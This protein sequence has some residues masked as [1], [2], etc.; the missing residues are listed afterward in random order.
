MSHGIE[1]LSKCLERPVLQINN[2]QKTINHM[3]TRSFTVVRASHS[4]K[5]LRTLAATTLV[6][7]LAACAGDDVGAGKLKALADGAQRPAVLDVMGSGP[8]TAKSDADQ[9]R[10]AN[11]YRRQLYVA[12]GNAV[13]VIWYREEPGTLDDPITT[14]KDTPVVLASDTLAGWGWNFYHKFAETNK[15]PDPTRDDERIDSLSRSQQVP[16]TPSN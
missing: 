10:L 15:I 6:L 8:L 5:T 9:V 12:G 2:S 3:I 1:L 13:E 4:M 16:R 11:G 14:G 7:T